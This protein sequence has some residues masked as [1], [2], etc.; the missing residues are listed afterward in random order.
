MKPLPEIVKWALVDTVVNI[1]QLTNT[2]KRQLNAAVKRGELSKGIGGPFP[3]M[4]TMW[5]RPGFDFVADRNREVDE[6]MAICAID[7]RLRAARKAQG[8]PV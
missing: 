7:D 4:K 6:A 8:S 3:K 2:E 1:G 5:A